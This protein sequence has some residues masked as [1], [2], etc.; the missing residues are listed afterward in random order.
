[1]TIGKAQI[2][3][4][5]FAG[6]DGSSQ[7]AMVPIS[8][9]VGGTS[10]GYIKL[11][12]TATPYAGAGGSEDG[13]TEVGVGSW[14]ACMHACMQGECAGHA[15]WVQCTWA[16]RFPPVREA[17]GTRVAQSDGQQQGWLSERHS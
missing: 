16:A 14:Q 2:D 11:V 6:D 8:F 17:C 4:A 3:M 13:M 1:M 9:K 10:T 5:R 12:I 15:A 7:N